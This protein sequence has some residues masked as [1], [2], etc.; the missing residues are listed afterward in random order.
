MK[1]LAKELDEIKDELTAAR[2]E[3]KELADAVNK[4]K[5]VINKMD[6]GITGNIRK[7]YGFTGSR[8]FY[9]GVATG[10]VYERPMR[11][12]LAKIMQNISTATLN[13]ILKVNDYFMG[14]KNG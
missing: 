10:T 3:I 9:I 12:D 13:D 4:A 2:L 6:F 1:D 5:K 7:S 8:M 14:I 11:K